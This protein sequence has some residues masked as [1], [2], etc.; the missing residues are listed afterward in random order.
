MVFVVDDDIDLLDLFVLMLKTNTQEEIRGF[1]DRDQVVSCLDMRPRVIFFDLL[2]PGM[3]NTR[4]VGTLRQF[5]PE[6]QLVLMSAHP[7]VAEYAH[8]LQIRDWIDKTHAP[9]AFGRFLLEKKN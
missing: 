1:L 3:D 2:M 5:S 9:E 8:N 4:F 7:L 6:S